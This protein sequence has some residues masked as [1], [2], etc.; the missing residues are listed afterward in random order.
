M[1]F[2]DML[3][4]ITALSE[5]VEKTKT[6]LKHKADPGGYGRKHDTDEEGEEK[7]EK[8]PEVKRGRGRPKKGS[9]ETGEKKEYDWSAFGV[10]KGKDVKLPKHPKEKTKTHKLK[11]Y[12]EEAE[13]RIV[14][15]MMTQQPIPVVSKQGSTQSTGAGFLNID[16]TSP[17]G[18]A[19]KDAIGKLAQ[20]KKAQI[21]VPTTQ[22]SSTAP[23]V[24]TGQAPAGQQKVAEVDY[25][26]KKARAGK[27]IGKPGKQFSKIAKSAAERY[28][29]KERGEKVAGAVLAKLR[30]KTN[31]AD[32]PP[33]DALASPL[34]MEAKKA[35][36]DYIDLDKD[37][38][39]KESMKKAASDAKKDKKKVDES[40]NHKHKAAHHRGKSH[41][42]AKEGYNCHYED[43]EEARCYHEGYK[44]G[45]DECYGMSP[46]MGV[47]VGEA[48]AATVPGMAD[49]AMTAMEADIEEMDK[50]EWMKHKAKT[51]PGDTFKAFGQTFK[52]K[53][54]L[55]SPFAF[56]AWDS[57]LQAL[58]ES[59]EDVSEGMTVSISKGQQ[60]APDSVSVSAQD[61]EADQLLSLI[62]SA[63]LGLFGKEA[64]AGPDRGTPI[65]VDEPTDKHGDI[66][67]VGDHDGMMALIKKVT[68]AGDSGG[69]YEKEGGHDH[70]DECE[71]CGQSPCGCDDEEMVEDETMDQREEEVAEDNAPD[72]DAAETTA[73]EN[74]EA[75]EDE[76]LAKADELNEWANEAMKDGTKE[77]FVTDADFMINDITSGLNKRKSTGQ[78][79]VPVIAGQMNRMVSQNTTDVNES[80]TDWKKLAGIK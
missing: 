77:A 28:G 17:A 23:A 1:N 8:K 44:E 79:T 73:D 48:P 43:M 54:V 65:V 74:A 69:D 21:V 64:E 7:K 12:F 11:E 15:E 57:Q 61:G 34:T 18:Q 46:G 62:K 13:K 37:G 33:N 26:A 45:L 56:E 78:T 35:K 6:G 66:D 47:V 29:S 5:A 14:A 68:G 60:G 52:D 55:E 9:D 24:A 30:A 42:L 31:E 16:D 10:K 63:G 41:A 53:E 58:L 2:K 39:K 22:Q 50:S 4:K 67:V 3:E 27:D 70:D 38:N 19:M 32:Q 72:S 25:S 49:Q 71:T 20:Q 59:K 40:M 51:T 76:A 80:I 75:A 36:P